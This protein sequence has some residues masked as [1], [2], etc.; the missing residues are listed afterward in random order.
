LFNSYKAVLQDRVM[1]KYGS[2]Q[3]DGVFAVTGWCNWLH[4]K[5]G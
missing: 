4:E 5:F 1:L 3:V 2:L